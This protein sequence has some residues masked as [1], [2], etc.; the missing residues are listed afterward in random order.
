MDGFFF[1]RKLK[2]RSCFLP[3]DFER[4]QRSKQNATLDPRATTMGHEITRVALLVSRFMDG[5]NI[6]CTNYLLMKSF[7]LKDA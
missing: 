1:S 2:L 7:G 4:V 5:L 6:C 3:K